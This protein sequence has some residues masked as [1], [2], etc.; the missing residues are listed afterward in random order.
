MT[1]EGE[2]VRSKPIEYGSFG[3]ELHRMCL[4]IRMRLSHFNG[5]VASSFKA[6]CFGRDGQWVLETALI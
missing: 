4:Y 5:I 6:S 2:V 3:S 1:L